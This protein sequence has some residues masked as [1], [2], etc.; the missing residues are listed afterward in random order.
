MQWGAEDHSKGAD[1][2]G[3]PHTSSPL[4]LSLFLYFLCKSE[5][6]VWCLIQHYTS[7]P[8]GSSLLCKQ[9][10]DAAALQFRYVGKKEQLRHCGCE[11]LA[12]LII[13]T[14]ASPSVSL[15]SYEVFILLSTLTPLQLVCQSGFSS[16]FRGVWSFWLTFF[17][18][19]SLYSNE[20]LFVIHTNMFAVFICISVQA[21]HGWEHIFCFC[22]LCFFCLFLLA[23]KS[24]ATESFPLSER[25]GK[26]C[27]L[28][29]QSWA[30][31]WFPELIFLYL[32]ASYLSFFPKP[33]PGWTQS[34]ILPGDSQSGTVKGSKQLPS[35]K[36]SITLVVTP[37]VFFI[38]KAP[39]ERQ[40]VSS[41]CKG[42]FL[43]E[44]SAAAFP[45]P[46]FNSPKGK[47]ISKGRGNSWE[48]EAGT[49]AEKWIDYHYLH[50]EL[51][52]A[53]HPSSLGSASQIMCYT[54]LEI[55]VVSQ[56]AEGCAIT[57]IWMYTCWDWHFWL[58]N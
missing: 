16:V 1:V 28:S 57:L 39:E 52:Y 49:R 51:T 40:V 47:L 46:A 27:P 36:Y 25:C 31:H 15:K 4:G 20:V 21:R 41:S 56:I 29:T 54:F 10:R 43:M 55:A 50:G 58:W 19:V 11:I 34:F 17:P 6:S 42:D 53:P 24:G 30:G 45:P 37:S 13:F 33:S 2:L 35:K 22:L 23:L 9:G 26:F 38:Y 3:Y 5:T 32:L 48:R 14:H 44:E 8:S 12:G 18:T 7:H